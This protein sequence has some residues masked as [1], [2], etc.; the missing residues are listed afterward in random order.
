MNA[1]IADLELG[2]PAGH[3][4]EDDSASEV[5]AAD[6]P[7]SGVDQALFSC[8][9][10]VLYGRSTK[11]DQVRSLEDEDE[12]EVEVHIEAAQPRAES[13][14]RSKRRDKG[15]KKIVEDFLA[16]WSAPEVI[17]GKKHSQASDV[18]SFAL[19]LWEILTA[20]VPFSHIKKQDDIRLEV[21]FRTYCWL[22]CT[23]SWVVFS[24][25][26]DESIVGPLRPS[27]GDAPATASSCLQ[28]HS[29]QQR[30]PGQGNS[31]SAGQCGGPQ[32]KSHGGT[33]GWTR[34]G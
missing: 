30:R 34:R 4:S 24:K 15:K 28:Q 2:T 12:D 19:V 11:E 14:D 23:H 32:A 21:T 17:E 8:L 22:G 33:K 29:Q 13:V 5:K 26:S 27:S 1:K 25:L 10:R 3:S 18:Y 6:N 20:T 9:K 16:N 31:S 7:V